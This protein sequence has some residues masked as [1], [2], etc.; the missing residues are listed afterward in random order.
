MPC[1][2]V[3]LSLASCYRSFLC[4]HLFYC[5]FALLITYISLG[6]ARAFDALLKQSR[7]S[8]RHA[9]TEGS[10]SNLRTQF[11]SYFAF[12][13]YYERQPLP[14]DLDTVRA[15]AQFLSRSVQ[16]NTILNYLSGL[17]MLH[18]LLGF[19]Y[20]F[21][22]HAILRLLLRGLHRLHPYTPNRAPPITPGILLSVFGALDHQSSLEACVF[23]CGLF[24]FFTMSRLG[25]MLPKSIKHIA[26]APQSFLTR[27]RVNM[28]DAQFLVVSFL[29]T[30][31]IQFGQRTLHVPLMRSDSPLCPVA[32][33]LHA[34]DLLSDSACAPAFAYKKPDGASH[35]LLPQEFVRVFRTLLSRA[36]V[37][38][39]AQFRGHSFR[40]GGASWAF[41]NGVPGE[42]I[43]VM[44]DWKSDAY[45]VYLEF[46]LSSK[47]AIAER[48][49]HNLPSS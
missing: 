36:G 43:Q 4:S 11:R 44:G 16:H 13:V 47:V 39:A 34:A 21:T 7:R 1:D 42:L 24:L 18:I 2:L 38:L 37:P 22:G 20:P 40:R 45:K 19:S 27:A 49:I 30:K 3:R 25:S 35:P 48:L 9:F 32:A 17:K 5:L 33:Y 23:S 31:T 41:N 8:Q 29:H 14:A 26:R 15:Y 46:S 28:A 12:C 6:A 10:H